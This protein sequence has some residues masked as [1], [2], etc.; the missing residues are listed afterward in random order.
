MT[1][2][3]YNRELFLEVTPFGAIRNT[4]AAEYNLKM[5]KY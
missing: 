5:Y 3:I 4:C 1:Y 2:D